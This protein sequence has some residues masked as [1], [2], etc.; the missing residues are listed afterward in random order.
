MRRSPGSPT[1]GTSVNAAPTPTRVAD[2]M[3]A[4]LATLTDAAATQESAAI[5]DAAVDVAQSA[6]DLQLRYR[7]AAAVDVERFHLHSQQLRI[8]AA[9]G[10]AA[11]VA[12]EVATLEWIRDRIV[13]TLTPAELATVDDELAQ[14]RD[15]V[16]SGNLA[17][18]ADEAARLA[19]DV[20]TLSVD[21][22][23]SD[24]YGQ[25]EGTEDRTPRYRR[26]QR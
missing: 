12:A 9:A 2:A 18:A 26:R 24:S 8:D 3:D 10:D 13:G 5:S 7:P 15:A 22:A 25:D 16:N 20:R 21:N 1:T 6:L 23:S 14:L 19:N 11:G 4:A 17:A